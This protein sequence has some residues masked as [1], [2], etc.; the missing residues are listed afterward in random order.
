VHSE[1]HPTS[2]HIGKRGR[3]LLDFAR[4]FIGPGLLDLAGWYGTVDDPVPARLRELIE[5]YVNAGGH[6]DALAERAG[7]PAEAW[8]LG[9]H[10]VWA[11][12]W[13]MEQAIRWINDP[14]ADPAYVKVV[15]RHLDDAVRL[16]ET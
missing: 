12:E 1:F 8:A 10:R 4:A 7:L 15:R 11:V 3:Y 5:S 14:A 16:L 9:W 13:F 2:V 6:P